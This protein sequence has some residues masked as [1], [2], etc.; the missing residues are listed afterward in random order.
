MESAD[1]AS[2]ASGASVEARLDALEAEG[3]RSYD[4]PACDCV[5]TLLDRAAERGGPGAARVRER[6]WA[7]G[8]AL[9]ER[10][11]RD[12]QRIQQRLNETE[13]ERGEL[14]ELRA[15]LE[16]GELTFAARAIRRWKVRPKA[17]RSVVVTVT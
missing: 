7:H 10:Y 16:R 1:L 5:R 11:A 6:A 14:P 12:R 15:R 8:E 17:M 13:A 3:A 4:A 9:A 2:A